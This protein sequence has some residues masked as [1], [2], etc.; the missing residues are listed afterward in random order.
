MTR[1]PAIALAMVAMAVGATLLW[2]HAREQRERVD[3]PEGT[4]WMCAGCGQGFT[5]S[6]KELGAWY[7]GHSNPPPCPAC[8]QTHTVRAY[9]CRYSNCRSYFTN[10]VSV[11]GRPACPKCRRE[12]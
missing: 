6:V 5:K 10:S 7:A 8:G 1:A 2:R 3:F 9:R 11:A 12:M 4:Y